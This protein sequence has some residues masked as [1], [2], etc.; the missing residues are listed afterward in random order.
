M[1][2]QDSSAISATITLGS[3]TTAPG[4]TN[5]GSGTGVA[6]AASLNDVR[7]GA[8]ASIT[9]AT[10]TATGGNVLVQAKEMAT[11]TATTTSEVSAGS[12]STPT[13]TAGSTTKSPLAID[14]LIG[15]NLVQSAATATLS[16]S[17]V[18]A[19]GTGTGVGGVTVNAQNTATLTAM[20]TNAATASTS[21]SGSGGGSSGGGGSGNVAVGV[22]L[23]FNTIGW[24]SENV[25]FSAINALLGDSLLAGA[26]SGENPSNATA[27][28]LD[29]T[30]IATGELTVSAVDATTITSTIGNT[31]TAS[32][33]GGTGGT[34]TTSGQKGSQNLALGFVLA[35]N[36]VLGSAQATI[37]FDTGNL[38]ASTIQAAG[39]VS[40]TAQD[41]SGI[42]AT[43]TLGSS[44][45][46]PGGSNS[47]GSTGVAGAVS[48]NDVRGGATASITNT[49]LSATGGNVLVQAKEMAT[50]TA[51]TTSEVT[52][53]SSSTPT[54]T[55][56]STT[57]SPLAIDG[58]IGTNLVQS[59]ATATLG[60]SHVTTTGTGTGWR[61][62]RCPEHGQADGHDHQRGDGVVLVQGG[63]GSGG[64]GG[65]GNTAV[66]VTLAFNT[67]GW[68]SQNVLFNA[69]DALLGSPT[70]ANAF[71]GENPSDATATMLDTTVSASGELTVGAVDSPTITSTITNTSKANSTGLMGASGTAVAVVLSMNKV[72]S[73]AE[74][75]INY[76]SSFTPP[77]AAPTFRAAG[78]VAVTARDTSTISSTLILNAAVTSRRRRRR[79]P[80]NHEIDRRGGGRRLQRR[81]WRRQRVPHQ[82]H[83]QRQRQRRRGG[84]GA[85]SGQPDRDPQRR[86]R[87]LRPDVW[88]WQH[89]IAR[90]RR[91]HLDQRRTQRRHRPARQQQRHDGKRQRPASWPT[92][93]R[94]S[95]PPSPTR[96]RRRRAARPGLAI[97][98]AFNS[99]GWQAQNVLFNTVDALLGDPLIS[100]ALG[101]QIPSARPPP[102]SIR[103]SP[104]AAPCP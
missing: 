22:T 14:G 77:R 3:S 21:T 68:E 80:A 43:I 30:V 27:T 60:S 85:G 35:S 28:M 63:G 48:L 53:G 39:G 74:A 57:K 96:S 1:T 56:G 72:S 92:T 104:P 76:D 55:S 84:D 67:I 33:S 9:S 38:A 87:H 51:T 10:L 31:T 32:T 36:K 5:A 95:R 11:L 90:R 46:A 69:I 86:G 81:R 40:V 45:T 2:A 15:T 52:A 17:Q 83:D 6:G 66:G 88:Q 23:A 98:L 4:G 93:L 78:G 61:H 71:G 82:C 73:A 42:S 24:E 16:H 47:G 94:P 102:W 29:T 13:T 7:G 58:L 75:S 100:M 12:S 44:S 34:G 62:R 64:S 59:A 99:I 97:T 41:S 26:F 25:L 79:R 20:T 8:T 65:S 101:D 49:T 91:P 103:R 19:A 50:L 89:L 18:T 54:T 37:G 70:L